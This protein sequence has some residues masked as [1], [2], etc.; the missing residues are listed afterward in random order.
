MVK[1]KLKIPT[2]RLQLTKNTRNK[3]DINNILFAHKIL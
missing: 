2:P 3:T 1:N